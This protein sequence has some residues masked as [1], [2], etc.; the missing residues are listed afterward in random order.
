[1]MHCYD[2]FPCANS[3]GRDRERELHA[4]ISLGLKHFRTNN[5][6]IEGRS[7]RAAA[8]ESTER[9]FCEIEAVF[10]PFSLPW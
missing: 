6:V 1:M 4:N 2:W 9:Y 8:W 5:T 3:R 7:T 10:G